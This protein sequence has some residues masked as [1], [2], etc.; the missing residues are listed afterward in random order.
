[1]SQK[2]YEPKHSSNQVI[3]DFDEYQELYKQSIDDPGTVVERA[4][5]ILTRKD[6]IQHEAACDKAMPEE[7]QIGRPRDMPRTLSTRAGSWSARS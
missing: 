7:L 3:K 5:T 1:M 6:A 4:E 2:I